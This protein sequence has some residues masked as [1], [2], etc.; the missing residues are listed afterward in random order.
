MKDLCNFINEYHNDGT[1]SITPTYIK[2]FISNKNNIFEG[3]KQQDASEFIIYLLDA[4]NDECNIEKLYE[5][6]LSI[7]IKCKLK[8]CLNISTHEEKNNFMILNLKKEF[9]NLDDCYHEY[10]SRYKFDNDSLYNCEKCNNKVIA[11][12]RTNIIHWPKHLIIILKRF[13]QNVT[14]LFKNDQELIIPLIWKNNY[15]LM[16]I[17][18]HSGSLFSGHYVYI[19]N[20]NNKWYLFNDNDVSEINENNFNKF[21]NYGYIYYF[22]KINYF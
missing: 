14:R 19:G 15:K 4:I 9:K 21:K 7:S 1:N 3:F 2:D 6:K 13:E 8:V 16:G 11:S 5:H 18:F 12:K 20:Y 10:V 17:V 22:E